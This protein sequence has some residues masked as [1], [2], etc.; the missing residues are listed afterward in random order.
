M[1]VSFTA[2]IAAI[3]T[4]L[5]SASI[6]AQ[7]GEEIMSKEAGSEDSLKQEVSAEPSTQVIATYFHG[8]RRCATC[9][10]LEAYSREALE[11][12]FAEELGDSSF[13]W[14]TV[15]YDRAENKHFLKD[16]E[17]YTKALILSKVAGGEEIGWRNL[18]KIWELVRSKED[19]INYVQ[20]ETRKFVESP[21]SDE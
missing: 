11:T 20:S 15:N 5:M 6:R 7:Q 3:L 9:R 16:Y 21:G 1:K 10:K 8:D 14:R 4:V 13:V 19:F 17:L 12:G 2:V 18:D